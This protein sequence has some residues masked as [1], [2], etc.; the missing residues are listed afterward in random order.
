MDRLDLA[1]PHPLDLPL[2]LPN[3]PPE[4][5]RAGFPLLATLAPV[6]GALGLWAVTGSAF[7][8]V[9]AALG[10]VVAMASLLDSRRQARRQRRRAEA[11]RFRR[12]GALRAAIDE[13]HEFERRAAWRR[14][15]PSR[16]LID[17]DAAPS[18][19]DGT[20]GPVVLGRGSAA[21]TLRIDGSP[22]DD[23][24]RAVLE[25][26]ALLADVPVTA[27]PEAGIGFVGSSPLACAA[28]RAALVQV[29]HHGVDRKSVV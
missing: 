14:S 27:D 11:E 26:A 2:A 20:P 24:D 6:V 8:L 28:A 29:A 19:S 3:M 22:A 18:W 23:A 13:R 15:P 9:F 21:S 1:S 12:L 5:T 10:P 7:A 16:H 4:A 17:G 25:H